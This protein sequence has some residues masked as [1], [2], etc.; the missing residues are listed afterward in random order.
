MKISEIA[1]NLCYF[2]TRNPDGVRS[3][4]TVEELNEEGYTS[5]TK[6]GCACDNCFYRRTE[7][8]LYILKLRNVI[9]S[10]VKIPD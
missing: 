6:H 9:P 4:M 8:A 5:T 7:L 1:S 2:D 10:D 3:F